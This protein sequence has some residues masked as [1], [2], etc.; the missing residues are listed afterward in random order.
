MT[1][2][3]DPPVDSRAKPSWRQYAKS[4]GPGLVTGASDDDPSGIA[5]YAQVAH[6]FSTA[7]CG[8]R[9]SRGR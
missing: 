7:S 2:L 4:L 1:A 8:P 3:A 5:T 6:S 9:S